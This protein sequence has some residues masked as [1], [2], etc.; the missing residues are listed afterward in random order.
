MKWLLIVIVFFLIEGCRS[1][2]FNTMS[3]KCDQYY[4]LEIGKYKL[5]QERCESRHYWRSSV[6][7]TYRLYKKNLIGKYKKI[8]N[9][10]VYFVDTLS[11]EVKFYHWRRQDK[12]IVFNIKENTL[13]KFKAVNDDIEVYFN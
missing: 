9:Y 3:V 12:R 8:D 4:S 2:G 5:T 13:Y 11:G 1:F 7:E 10:S 6:N